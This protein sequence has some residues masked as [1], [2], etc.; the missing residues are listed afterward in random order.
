MLDSVI[1][2]GTEPWSGICMNLCCLDIYINRL[3]VWKTHSVSVPGCGEGSV[4]A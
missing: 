2:H 4:A 3:L 1:R